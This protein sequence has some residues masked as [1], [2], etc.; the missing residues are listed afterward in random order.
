MAIKIS[1]TTVVDYPNAGGDTSSIA[2][3]GGALSNQNVNTKYNTALGGNALYTETTGEQNTAVGYGA[4][5]S[6][7]G[8][9]Y[10]T[11]VG[12]YAGYNTIESNNTYIGH[13]SGW[14][15]TSSSNNTAVGYRSL[16]TNISS[17][18][19]NTAI[20]TD[21]LYFADGYDYNTAIGYYAGYSV[22]GHRN[23]L[24]GYSAGSNI[25]SGAN[26]LILGDGMQATSSGITNE[27]NIG[28]NATSR[29]HVNSSGGVQFNSAFRFPTVD[30]L[31][32]YIL[33]TDG[34][35]T[36]SWVAAGG[37]GGTPGGSNTELQYNNSGSFGGMS[38]FQYISPTLSVVSGRIQFN[39]TSFLKIDTTS[40]IT[41]SGTP[42]GLHWRT[43]DPYYL[44]VQ[45]SSFY[46]GQTADKDL[47]LPKYNTDLGNISNRGPLPQGSQPL[48][49][50][51]GS[52]LYFL[53]DNN[54]R[55]NHASS[56]DYYNVF[57]GHN[58]GYGMQNSILEHNYHMGYEAAYNENS[59]NYNFS[60]G[61]QVAYNQWGSYNI[62]MGYQTA[63]QQNSSNQYNVNIGYKTAYNVNSTSSY[64]INLGYEANYNFNNS[65]SN[66]YNIA[67][68]Y[69][70]G[71]YD[72][73]GICNIALGYEPMYEQQNDISNYNIA[74]GY[75]SLYRVNHSYENHRNVAIGYQAAYGNG[76]GMSMNSSRE[77]DDGI[78]I[79]NSAAYEKM[80]GD[81]NIGIGPNVFYSG[82]NGSNAGD[83]NVC[84]I[85]IGE[86]AM[87]YIMG[88][89]MDGAALPFGRQY[90]VALGYYAGHGHSSSI[91]SYD[92]FGVYIGH[93]AGYNIGGE[94]NTDQYMSTD[95]WRNT[96]GSKN[97]FIGY[98]AGYDV[99]FGRGNVILGN[100]TGNTGHGFNDQVH[101]YAGTG[102]KRLEISDTTISIQANT[103]NVEVTS[104]GLTVNGSAVGGGASPITSTGIVGESYRGA[105]TRVKLT[106]IGGMSGSETDQ[107]WYPGVFGD[108]GQYDK[109]GEY[110]NNYANHNSYLWAV[111]PPGWETAKTVLWDTHA[112]TYVEKEWSWSDISSNPSWFYFDV[113]PAPW[114]NAHLYITHDSNMPGYMM[115]PSTTGPTYDT[116]N[117][118][119]RESG[120]SNGTW[121][122]TYSNE[123]FATRNSTAVA[124]QP[125]GVLT[126]S[127]QHGM[128]PAC[129]SYC[130]SNYYSE[131][132]MERSTNAGQM[133]SYWQD[134]SMPPGAN[135]GSTTASDWLTW[136]TS[137][138]VWTHVYDM[139]MIDGWQWD[140]SLVFHPRA[141]T[142]IEIECDIIWNTN[143]VSEKGYFAMMVNDGNDYWNSGW[144]GSKWLTDYNDMT[145]GT[146]QSGTTGDLKYTRLKRTLYPRS[147]SDSGQWKWN[148]RFTGTYNPWL[149]GLWAKC[150]ND[151]TITIYNYT[152]RAKFYA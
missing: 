116:T 115:Y 62:N 27:I 118:I 112:S 79:G 130:S 131:R 127:Q 14:Q 52:N 109:W 3:G 23:T 42:Y 90:N 51:M 128:H 82:F 37:G 20:G 41:Y 70:P 39:N 76:F 11:A 31:A 18:S 77:A 121:L 78:Y 33:E 17:G 122:G 93:E 103:A 58:V 75:Q 81:K 88:D 29:I 134:G 59:G 9:Q 32:N 66:S 7:N 133:S 114:N 150:A 86:Y 143:N 139:Y 98:K 45:S 54:S 138:I 1:G 108:S 85:A 25:T 35:G 15:G 5:Y 67:I 89:S 48:I 24:L 119:W 146:S 8:Y 94:T 137:S 2:V 91:Y 104:S 72:M 60:V 55:P 6:Q 71:Y 47:W 136:T 142:P 34:A 100:Y 53:S 140:G 61:Y 74:I 63:Y 22:N 13:Y 107:E 10:N 144:N 95:N 129:I 141:G 46:S 68:G 126:S 38:E 123:Q 152:L 21:A 69:R 28:T 101:I 111:P 56:S 149:V 16:Y 151:N 92:R 64:N 80:T 57:I 40:G 12:Y 49:G 50:N 19:Y 65:F 147:Q 113:G 110:N 145:Y 96:R 102:T 97:I 30:G 125:Q 44:I 106:H 43:T 83:R 117:K 135:M 132:T 120:G 148:T 73:G 84:N 105:E 124:W 99:N 26:N 87:R 4:L 36:L